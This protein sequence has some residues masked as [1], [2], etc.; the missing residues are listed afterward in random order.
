LELSK[1]FGDDL[2]A[3]LNWEE[4]KTHKKYIA[5]HL[6]EY[7][8]RNYHVRTQEGFAYL[9]VLPNNEA[10]VLMAINNGEYVCFLENDGVWQKS[11][12]LE[13]WQKYS[14]NKWQKNAADKWEVEKRNLVLVENKSGWVKVH[15][16]AQ[17]I[18][19]YLKQSQLEE[20]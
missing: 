15:Y 13:R 2:L 18:E 8:V 1:Y 16:P 3:Q 17:G 5:D 11:N 6:K 19:G 14:T 10:A 20:R 12:D 9:R 7:V 4:R